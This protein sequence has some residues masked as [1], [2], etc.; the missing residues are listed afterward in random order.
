MQD[1][2]IL[3]PF[4][5]K[6]GGQSFTPKND[7]ANTT[8]ATAQFEGALQRAH[9]DIR[10][11]K[12]KDKPPGKPDHA[13]SAA[14]LTEANK[15]RAP[16]S[17]RV[18]NHVPTTIDASTDESI[19]VVNGVNV[20]AT[21]ENL[22][23]SM[24][25]MLRQLSPSEQEQLQTALQDIGNLLESQ[26]M[27]DEIVASIQAIVAEFTESPTADIFQ[28]LFQ[29]AG[30]NLESLNL[31]NIELR[32]G[33]QRG[34]LALAQAQ[35]ENINALEASSAGLLEDI[36]ADGNIEILD[37][38]LLAV[39]QLNAI[40]LPQEHELNATEKL[41][42]A[43]TAM[44]QTLNSSAG[45]RLVGGSSAETRPAS[46]G[47]MN[48][49]SALIQ[50]N[51]F[52]LEQAKPQG[53]LNLNASIQLAAPTPEGHVIQ[54]PGV[55]ATLLSTSAAEAKLPLSP[56]GRNFTLQTTVAPTV[57]RENW[58][59][60]VGQKVLW[61]ARQNISFA[62]MRLDPPDLGPMQVRIQIQ[63]D[64][65]QVSFI[66]QQPVVR[67]ALEQGLVRL[68]EMFEEQ[69]IDLVDVNVS[70]QSSHSNTES[71]DEA[72]NHQG[73]GVTPQDDLSDVE[74]AMVQER[75]L[76]LVDHYA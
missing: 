58:G 49:E 29:S 53:A 66:S 57:G 34:V 11:A 13:V 5:L 41:R 16:V 63:N 20:S 62:Q 33:L 44:Q 51:L 14:G 47:S 71:E 70:D 56:A 75:V 18:S 10:D 45:N 23:S 72:G 73:A 28:Q 17:D 30:V 32:Q 3:T 65:A 26:T 24:E 50:E 1:A 42:D 31:Q 52:N 35:A 37:A 55:D 19:Q 74:G 6:N 12:A 69:G 48:S 2:T 8:E 15:E 36:S 39:P 76:S 60:A 9:S 43:K 67:E 7:G 21:V 61:L 27:T 59:E 25:D 40:S 68:R 22:L 64:Q 38:S 46:S 4:P 54:E